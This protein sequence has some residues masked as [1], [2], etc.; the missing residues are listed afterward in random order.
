MAPKIKVP[1]SSWFVVIRA[2]FRFDGKLVVSEYW[3]RLPSLIGRSGMLPAVDGSY[4]LGSNDICACIMLSR[5]AA[6]WQAASVVV[7]LIFGKKLFC[8]VVSVDAL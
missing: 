6:L 2:G 5:D 4:S 7:Q 3:M 1:A 8:R